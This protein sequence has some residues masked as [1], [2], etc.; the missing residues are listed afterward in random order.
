MLKI[1][2]LQVSQAALRNPEDIKNMADFVRNNGFWTLKHLENYAEK[3]NLRQPSLIALTRFPDGM[4]MIHDGHHRVFSTFVG[5]RHY[6]RE[7]EY[8]IKDMLYQD[9]RIANPKAGW[10]TPFDPLTEV[11]VSD[12]QPYRTIIDNLYK[13]QLNDWIKLLKPMYAVPR[14]VFRIFDYY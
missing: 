11:R 14:N 6:L 12:L 4:L 8:T 7:D 1:E 13:G 3:Y 9:Y 10:I 2:E 5:S